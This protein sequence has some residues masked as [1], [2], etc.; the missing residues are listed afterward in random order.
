MTYK[1]IVE[2]TTVVFVQWVEHLIRVPEAGV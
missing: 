2:M 1:N